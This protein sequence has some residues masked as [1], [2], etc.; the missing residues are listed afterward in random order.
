[1]NVTS[2]GIDHGSDNN[3]YRT[4]EIDENQ[5]LTIAEP[6][7][8]TSP[9]AVLGDWTSVV[10][11]YINAGL[12]SEHTRRAYRRHLL[13]AQEILGVQSVE[14]V[15]GSG[16]ADYRAWI[17]SADLAPASQRQALAAVRSFLTWVGDLGGAAPPRQVIRTALRTPRG[18]SLTRYAVLTEAEVQRILE[19]SARDSRDHA[20]MT[21]LLG[22]GLR[23]AEVAALELGDVFEDASGGC[24]L[25]VRAGKGR[26]DRIVPIGVEVEAA[27]KAYL[28]DTARYLGGPGRLLLAVDKGA[29]TRTK[30]GLSTRA[31]SRIVK[32]LAM[33]AGIV[34]KKVSPHALRHSY[35][36]RSLKAGANVV[37]VGKLLGH[38][39]IATTQRYVDHLASTELRSAVPPLPMPARSA[40][41]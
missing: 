9:V 16:L 21:V 25:H 35:A 31:I 24:S 8:V 5:S 28:R 20:L 17:T 27:V 36:T 39:N 2:P 12:D 41:E 7:P 1:M 26:K 13:K 6:Y 34:T 38:S 40:D 30:R 33:S 4:Q 11:A 15:T 3:D 29:A 22:A 23:V 10:D 19:A 32:E 18:T 14:D 37:A